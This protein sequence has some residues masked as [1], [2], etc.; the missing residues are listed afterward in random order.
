MGIMATTDG[1]YTYTKRPTSPKNAKDLLDYY[2]KV[3]KDN[4]L[5]IAGKGDDKNGY[6]NSNC[7][8]GLLGVWSAADAEIEVPTLYWYLVAN[9]W[10]SKQ[11]GNGT[12]IYGE[13]R[14]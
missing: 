13:G 2:E 3:K 11:Q 5:P 1:S 10:M 14:E 12:W 6:D 7:Q 8:Y 4:K 9:H